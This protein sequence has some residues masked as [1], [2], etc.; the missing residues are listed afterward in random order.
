[1]APHKYREV[2]IGIDRALFVFHEAHNELDCSDEHFEIALARLRTDIVRLWASQEKRPA[3]VPL[4][5]APPP[6]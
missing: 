6:R 5:L 2:L 4:E 3:S 1:M